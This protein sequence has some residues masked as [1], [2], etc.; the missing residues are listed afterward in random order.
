MG[1]PASP[2]QSFARHDS[3]FTIG[4]ALNKWEEVD[5]VDLAIARQRSPA[6]SCRRCKKIKVV[7]GLGH[8]CTCRDHCGP[9]DEIGN[10]NTAFEERHL[11][12]SIWSI[13]L[14]QADVAGCAVVRRED[15]KRIFFEAVVLERIQH[16]T[17]PSVEG[18]DHRSVDSFAMELNVG[19]RIIVFLCRLQRRMRS[20]MCE[21]QEKGAILIRLDDLHRFVGVIVSQVPRR[22]ERFTPTERHGELKRTPEEPINWVERLLGVHDIGMVFG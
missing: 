14:G 6:R 20:P 15:H 4:L 10:A 17:D 19:E 21:I 5:A 3:S 16:L 18:P 11:P 1:S 7:S 12:T 8:G 22:L 2:E 13:H 9:P